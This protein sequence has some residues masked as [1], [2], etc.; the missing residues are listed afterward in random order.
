MFLSDN[1]PVLLKRGAGLAAVHGLWPAQRIVGKAQ[2]ILC[3][4]AE[5][6]HVPGGSKRNLEDLAG[7]VTWGSGVQAPLRTVL[8][9]AQTSGWL[10]MAVPPAALTGLLKALEAART[11]AA[12]VIGEVVQGRA[13]S[14]TVR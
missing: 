9:D 4:L 2:E 8:A 10:L 6:G 5:A 1:L 11:L 14:I 7:D 13:G 3:A 12:S